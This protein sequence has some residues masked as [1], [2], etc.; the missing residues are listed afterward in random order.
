MSL[1]ELENSAIGFLAAIPNRTPE[2]VRQVL[3]TFLQLRQ[4]LQETVSDEQLEAIA[5]SIEA[6]LIVNMTDAAKIQLPFEEWLPRRRGDASSYYYKRYRTWLESVRGFAPAVLGVMDKDT[7]KVVG[8]LE[9]PGRGGA[10]RRRGL[11]VGHVQSGKT[12]NY[13]GVICKAADYGYRFIVLLTGIQE[14]LRVQTQERIEDGFVGVNSEVRGQVDPSRGLTGVG[15]FG[16]EHR[17]M[18]L[19]SRSADFRAT[20]ATL[21]VPLQAAS[22]PVILVMKKNVRILAN[23][24]EWLQA[25]SQD[26]AGRI[27]GI[28][29]LL[30]DD[31]ADNASI[32]IAADADSP[33]SI[34]N[35]LRRLLDVFDRNAYIGYTATPFAN[36]FIDPDSVDAMCR[37]DLFPRDFIVSLDA[38][39]NYV[40][41]SRIFLEDG[42]LNS[43][44]EEVS[45]HVM[46]LPERHKITFEPGALPESLRRAVRS[47]IIARAVRIARGHG[48]DHSS[49][50]VNVSRFNSVQARITGLINGYL[51]ALRDACKGHAQLPSSEALR[52]PEI[53][54]LHETWLEMASRP[55][56]ETWEALL[57]LLGRAAGP[58]EVRTINSRS[59]DA[60]DYRKYR[61]TG[62]HV[63]AVG[64]LAL[65]RGFTLEGLLVSYFLRNSIMYD[66]LLQMGRWFGYRDGYEDICRI[67]MTSDA[68]SWYAHICEATE[69][70]REEFRLMERA[71]RVPQDF[72]LRV[73]S[74]PDSL[75]V[76][77]RN[78]MRSGKV[79]RHKVSLGGK[80]IET[81]AVREA[82]AARKR[83]MECL[84]KLVSSLDTARGAAHRIDLGY[85]WSDVS[86]VLVKDFISAFRNHDEASLKTQ[87]PAVVSYISAREM[88]NLSLWDVCLYSPQR[89][90][91][92]AS[93]TRVGTYR[94]SGQ[95]RTAELRVPAD[96]DGFLSIS[97]GAVR[98]ASRGAERAGMS[99]DEIQAARDEFKLRSPGQ[100]ISDKQYRQHRTRPLLMLHVLDVFY[101]RR[102]ETT[103]HE[104]REVVAWGVSFPGTGLED[105]DTEYVV[106]TRWWQDNFGDDLE[107]Y[108][109]D[110]DAT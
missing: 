110:A 92:H 51:N 95:L 98:V 7:D 33:S 55:I 21:T 13:T 24:I 76:T 53:R 45:D 67:F 81:A 10:W 107:E 29:M 106:N 94:V 97:K 3:R 35:A 70:L 83:N 86:A 87:A 41:A 56:P 25:N 63:I 88:E 72:G 22:E 69:E 18:A 34:N 19:T 82:S 104:A 32:N 61:E 79:V 17:P 43:C 62:L 1:L 52:D 9:D 2:K 57:P 26:S 11:V 84:E 85:L 46:L 38:P 28:P 20:N 73:R 60:L 100:S 75:I 49:M 99:A 14:I 93:S 80:L 96:G 15:A 78:K 5:K 39:T 101:T 30:I 89:P 8:L 108:A 102:G 66:T 40:G 23:L 16:L 54:D 6:K 36:I 103:E 4:D 105:A 37:Q 31:E 27:S 47:F 109:E 42:D 48:S 90:D 65:S 91:P 77:A 68:V 59:S 58:V 50:L 44:L 74:H 64:G 12:A 71:G